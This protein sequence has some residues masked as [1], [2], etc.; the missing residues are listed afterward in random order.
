MEVLHDAHSVIMSDNNSSEKLAVDFVFHQNTN[1]HDNNTIAKK[2]RKY[3]SN[4]ILLDLGYSY[5][6]L[7]NDELLANII[8]INTTL[9]CYTNDGH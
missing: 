4:D 5:L 2:F 9:R 8:D 6:V 3:P 1:V 7:N